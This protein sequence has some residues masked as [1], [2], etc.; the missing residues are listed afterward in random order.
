MN[1][2]YIKK[3]LKNLASIP[4]VLL[5]PTNFCIW[6]SGRCGST[7]LSSMLKQHPNI[8]CAEELL[9]NYSREYVKSKNNLEGWSRGK[10]LIRLNMLKGGKKVSGF[11]MKMAHLN[12]LEVNVSEAVNF[13]NKIGYKKYIVLERQNYLRVFV[14][15]EVAKQTSL[16]HIDS[17]K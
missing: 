3:K 1:N 7:I 13:L 16:Y 10:F 4:S 14:S 5:R 8:Y 17:R 11:E 9:E 15:R 2:S 12:R 6:H